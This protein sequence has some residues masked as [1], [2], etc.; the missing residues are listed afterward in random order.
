MSCSLSR[1]RYST[2]SGMS[3]SAVG[4][5]SKSYIIEASFSRCCTKRASLAK[6]RPS[7]RDTNST[8]EG[9]RERPMRPIGGLFLVAPPPPSKAF[10]APCTYSRAQAATETTKV[11]PTEA[12]VQ[13]VLAGLA[14]LVWGRFLPS[15][16]PRCAA[17]SATARHETRAR[18][19]A[20]SPAAGAAGLA[21][22]LTMQGRVP[23]NLLRAQGLLPSLPAPAW[24]PPTSCG[25]QA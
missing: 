9:G 25:W 20:G 22:S 4:V 8:F 13:R 23:C 5:R 16:Q 15:T 7:R 6:F 24:Q 21:E 17:P 14:S 19:S 3:F 18:R 10:S 12:E 11:C 2:D 1:R